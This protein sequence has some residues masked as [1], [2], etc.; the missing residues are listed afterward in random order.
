V[1]T[2]AVSSTKWAATEGR[3]LQFLSLGQKQDDVPAAALLNLILGS[4]CRGGPP[5]PPDRRNNLVAS[6]RAATEGRPYN[7]YLWAKSKLTSLPRRIIE[8]DPRKQL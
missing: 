4:N 5:W 7:F 8:L 2:H 1:A 3:P 6:E